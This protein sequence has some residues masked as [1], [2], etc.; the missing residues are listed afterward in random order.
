MLRASLLRSRTASLNDSPDFSLLTSLK[1]YSS[2]WR[3]RFSVVGS[4]KNW[5]HQAGNRGNQPLLVNCM[6]AWEAEISLRER[7]MMGPCQ[8]VW[9]QADGRVCCPC[10][11]QRRQLWRGQGQLPLFFAA[12]SGWSSF[13][14]KVGGSR[15]FSNDLATHQCVPLFWKLILFLNYDTVPSPIICVKVL[16]QSTRKKWPMICDLSFYFNRHTVAPSV[17][18]WRVVLSST[19]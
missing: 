10:S 19:C 17:S 13:W 5:Q 14:W 15:G 6:E 8:G 12:A 16:S 3:G 1:Y 4:V 9:M 11:P 2:T 18:N 7:P